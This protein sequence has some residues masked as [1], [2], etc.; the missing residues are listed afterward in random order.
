MSDIP[1]NMQ[2][3]WGRVWR[4]RFSRIFL[5]CNRSWISASTK[6]QQ[7]CLI[8]IVLSRAGLPTTSI[9]L[10]LKL[11]KISLASSTKAT[12]S[13]GI[14][15]RSTTNRV[16]KGIFG[17]RDLTKRRCGNREND[18][19]IDRTR[20]LTVPGKRDSPK[21]GHG[22][23]DLCLRVGRECPI[24]SRPTGSSGQS[25]STRRA[26]SGVSFQT[27]HPIGCLVNRSQWLTVSI[28]CQKGARGVMT[29]QLLIRHIA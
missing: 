12:S 24:P 8:L 2:A 4:A 15:S 5:L 11:S 22:M 18:K 10:S 17:I 16:W 27:K 21:T 13:Q 6:R 28:R 3:N 23:R 19:Y 7:R 9:N 29:Y 26:L 14:R 20:D 25:K 1:P